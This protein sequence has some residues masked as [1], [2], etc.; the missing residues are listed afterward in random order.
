MFDYKIWRKNLQTNLKVF[1]TGFSP[2]SLP[3]PISFQ[4]HQ[5]FL[6]TFG[7]AVPFLVIDHPPFLVI[8][9]AISFE[10]LIHRLKYSKTMFV[11]LSVGRTEKKNVGK[12]CKH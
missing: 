6:P 12:N 4:A 2:F 11:C 5:F 9:H 8:D 1:F 10:Y 3:L 7:H